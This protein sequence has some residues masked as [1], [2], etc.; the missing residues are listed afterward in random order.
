MIKHLLISLLSDVATILPHVDI[1][2]CIYLNVF[3]VRSQQEVQNVMAI[4]F[5]HPAPTA[6]AVRTTLQLLVIVRIYPVDERSDSYLV[7]HRK[8]LINSYHV[9]I[10]SQ[11]RN[12]I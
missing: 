9:I 2:V 4:E 6:A 3:P 1:A 8:Y 10:I 11:E 7:C 5:C 12:N